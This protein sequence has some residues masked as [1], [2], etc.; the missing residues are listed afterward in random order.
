MGTEVMEIQGEM[1][2]RVD[3]PPPDEKSILCL[4][5]KTNYYTLRGQYLRSILYPKSHSTQFYTE[6]IQF[7]LI[8]AGITLLAWV[9][10][11]IRVWSYLPLSSMF[12]TLL[13]LLTTSIPPTLPT[14]MSVGIG[15]AIQRLH[16][17]TIRC[18]NPQKI[19]VGGEVETVCFEKTGT[20]TKKDMTVMGFALCENRDIKEVITKPEQIATSRYAA[21]AF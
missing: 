10:V 13:D 1:V 7:L 6:S 14:A 17:I 5:T 19:L 2:N 20:L 11:C 15:F 3:V 12:T 18:S 21:T 16:S 4:S 8:I 9:I